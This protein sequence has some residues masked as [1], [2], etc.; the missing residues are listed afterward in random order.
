MAG[1]GEL[2]GGAVMAPGCRDGGGKRGRV[3]GDLGV[4]PLLP[5]GLRKRRVVPGWVAAGWK[6]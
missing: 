5:R 4:L 6:S 1:G 2:G 3:A